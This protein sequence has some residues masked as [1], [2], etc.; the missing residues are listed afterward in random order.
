LLYGQIADYSAGGK[1][2]SGGGKYK[3]HEVKKKKKPTFDLQ[4][5]SELF[6]RNGVLEVLKPVRAKVISYNAA[7][8]ERVK[9]IHV[10]DLDSNRALQ[11]LMTV[12]ILCW[13]TEVAEF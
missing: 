6:P 5:R 12:S 1:E 9:P 10:G 11:N 4:W 7:P 2:I 8:T 3:R 13:Q